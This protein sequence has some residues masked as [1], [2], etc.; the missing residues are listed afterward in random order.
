MGMSNSDDEEAIAEREALLRWAD[1]A[2][3]HPGSYD[4]PVSEEESAVHDHEVKKWKER[5]PR[6]RPKHDR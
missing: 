2:P 3:E 5:K 6:R 1:E 4:Y